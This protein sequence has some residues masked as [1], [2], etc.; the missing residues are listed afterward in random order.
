[1]RTIGNIL[2]L[3]VVGLWTALEWVIAGAILCLTVVGIPFGL[4]CFKLA[5]YS[6]WPFGRTV[7]PT[8]GST[9]VLGAI[10]NVVWFVL[11]GLWIAISYVVAGVLLCITL[12][13]IPFGIQ[14]FKLA[15][16]AL[17]PFGREVVPA[18]GQGV[19]RRSF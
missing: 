8:A 9:P 4:Q 10:A 13:G 7:V 11:A 1:V 19:D 16:L 3:I 17:T 18:H 14:A 15:G 2:W 6:L 5:E 12:I